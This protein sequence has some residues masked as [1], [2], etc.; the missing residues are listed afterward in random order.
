VHL[1]EQVLSTD[2]AQTEKDEYA[3]EFAA[4]L[5]LALSDLLAL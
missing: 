1:V 5:R 4:I 2:R 3:G